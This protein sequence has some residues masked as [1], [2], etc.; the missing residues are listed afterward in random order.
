M[1]LLSRAV[2]GIEFDYILA[3]VDSTEAAIPED[4]FP[5]TEADPEPVQESTQ[6][7]DQPEQSQDVTY[8]FAVLF[9]LGII[10]GLLFF[11]VFSRRWK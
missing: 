3:A 5:E 11:S 9:A 6:V 7:A 2:G 10:V 4:H 1:L 8:S